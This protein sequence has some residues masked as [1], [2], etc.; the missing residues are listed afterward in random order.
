ML[1]IRECMT[2]SVITV[3][4][5]TLLEDALSILRQHPIRRLPVVENKKLVGLLT[6]EILRQASLSTSVTSLSTLGLRYQ[7]LRMRV[8]D[9]MITDVITITPD[10]SLEEAVT[11]AERHQIGTLPV[12]DKEGNLVG[13]VTTTDL[14]NLTAH[15]LGFGQK[16]VRLF[17]LGLGSPEDIRRYQIM[18]ILKRHQVGFLSA[19]DVT[20]PATLQKYFVI[21]PNTEDTGD[22]V[23]ELKKLDLEVEIRKA[24]H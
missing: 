22:I 16:G 3:T 11:L 18:E 5:D 4:P 14:I 19:F 13:M 6:R 20:P 24:P 15:V 8:R 12:V 10:T 21:H 17:I 7:L 2:S 9:V 1:Y 23:D